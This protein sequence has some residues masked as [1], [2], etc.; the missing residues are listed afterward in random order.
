[1]KSVESGLA[2]RS[3]SE[4]LIHQRFHARA[5]S[6]LPSPGTWV[7]K[8]AA[9][10]QV[11]ATA[12]AAYPAVTRSKGRARRRTAEAFDGL[13][14]VLIGAMISEGR[15]VV[16]GREGPERVGKGSR[17]GNRS[18]VGGGSAAPLSQ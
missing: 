11:R 9:S 7:V 5:G 6:S 2:C 10:G 18:P 12:S 15:A 14:G 3:R 1:M 4:Y 17:T 8:L 16:K 13:V